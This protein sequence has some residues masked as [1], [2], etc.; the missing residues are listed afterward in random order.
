MTEMALHRLL[1]WPRSV[2]FFC[3]EPVN[4]SSSMNHFKLAAGLPPMASHLSLAREPA[5]TSKSL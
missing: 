4:S 3:L 5:L 1:F 2:S